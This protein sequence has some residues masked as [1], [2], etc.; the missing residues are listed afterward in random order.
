MAPGRREP[1]KLVRGDRFGRARVWAVDPLRVGRWVG[2]GCRAWSAAAWGTNGILDGARAT[3][4]ME[5][6]G[7]LCSNGLNVPSEAPPESEIPD[8]DTQ[9]MERS[10]RRTEETARDEFTSEW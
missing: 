5:F 4:C 2:V 6:E 3:G 10:I 7:V 9:L 1:R 8:C